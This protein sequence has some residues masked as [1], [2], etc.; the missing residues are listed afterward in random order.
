MVVQGWIP[1]TYLTKSDRISG[2]WY[3]VGLILIFF[4]GEWSDPDP[5]KKARI[6]NHCRVKGSRSDPQEKK[7]NKIIQKT[8]PDPIQK[9]KKKKV[10]ELA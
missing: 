7:E 4:F 5:L 8:G 10:P 6:L 3:S 9:K 2:F 1:Y